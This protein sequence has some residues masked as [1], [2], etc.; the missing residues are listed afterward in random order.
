MIGKFMPYHLPIIEGLIDW[1]TST[2]TGGEDRQSL[3]DIL[4]LTTTLT[5]PIQLPDGGL[6]TLVWISPVLI[7]SYQPGDHVVLVLPGMNNSSETGFVRGLA[8][9]ISNLTN[10]P[11]GERGRRVHVAILD[12][13]LTGTSNMSTYLNR[14]TPVVPATA[15]SWVDVKFVL[16]HLQDNYS[17]CNVHMVGQSLGGAITLKYLGSRLSSTNDGVVSGVGICPPVDYKRVASHLEDGVVSRVCNFIMTLPCKL[18]VIMNE[19]V[20]RELPSL[21][22]TMTGWT[23]RDFER[24]VVCTLCGFE[25][26][27]D[28]YDKTTPIK[29]MGNITVP[30][31]VLASTDDPIVPPP[32]EKEV[33]KYSDMVT[34]AQVEYGGHLG[35]WDWRG[36]RWGDRV[37][38]EWIVGRVK[39]Y[40]E[41]KEREIIEGGERNLGGGGERM[42]K[43]GN[44]NRIMRRPS[45]RGVAFGF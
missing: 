25:T 17:G 26:P 41:R 34:V 21:W 29:T 19:R 28:Y 1:V 35:L 18:G 32:T 23:V 9:H 14:E 3:R 4:E 22:R 44:S 27:E 33:L 36:N 10:K 6:L 2:L 30:T 20:R 24:E 11:H 38:G 37:V 16:Q 12:Y 15:Q 13:R 42:V 39:D 8:L 31:L 7:N 40:E 45:L 5:E 43:K